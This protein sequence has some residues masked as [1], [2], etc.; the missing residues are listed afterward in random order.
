MTAFSK[1]D[2]AAINRILGNP[3]D[4]LFVTLEQMRHYARH[5]AAEVRAKQKEGRKEAAK[6]TAAGKR[7]LAELAVVDPIGGARPVDVESKGNRQDKSSQG[8]RHPQTGEPSGSMYLVYQRGGDHEDILAADRAVRRVLILLRPAS[9]RDGRSSKATY[10][11]SVIRDLAAIYLRRTR[12][13]PTSS[14]MGDF[15]LLVTIV[16]RLKD[17]KDEIAAALSRKRRLKP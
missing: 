14:P 16:T 10:L 1:L 13:R 7:F 3:D 6:V 11:K 9:G 15:A 4:R 5:R 17:P 8:P 12:R 2:R